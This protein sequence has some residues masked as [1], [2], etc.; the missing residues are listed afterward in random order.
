MRL[1]VHSHLRAVQKAH[2]Q[3]R[4]DIDATALDPAVLGDDFDYVVFNYPHVGSDTGLVNIHRLRTRL[5]GT[6]LS[7]TPQFVYGGVGDLSC[8]HEP[9]CIG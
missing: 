9:P 8:L 2:A 5:Y 7:Q 3:A 6:G 1:C 4:H